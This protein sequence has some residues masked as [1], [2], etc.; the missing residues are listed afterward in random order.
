MEKNSVS[1]RYTAMLFTFVFL[2]GFFIST[3]VCEGEPETQEVSGEQGE[4]QE[5]EEVGEESEQ[6]TTT[7][8]IAAPSPGP[9]AP[10]RS[11]QPS[12][13]Q[14]P[15]QPAGSE[16]TAKSKGKGVKGI[17]KKFAGAVTKASKRYTAMLFTFVFL[18]GFFIS[19]AV[20]EEEPEQQDGPEEHVEEQEPEEVG[21]E[22]EQVTTTTTTA[23]PSP[24]P[25]PSAR[26]QPSGA[27]N[28]QPPTG[29]QKTTKSKGKGV[30]GFAKKFAGAVAKGVWKRSTAMLF[31]YVFL[32]GLLISTAVCQD[33]SEQQVASGE[34]G[35]EEEP[36]EEVAEENVQETTTTTATPSGG[37]KRPAQLPHRGGAQSPQPSAAPTKATKSKGA[38]V[39]GFAK[40]FAGAV[41][42]GIWK[43]STAM[44]FTYVF[45]LGFLISTAV[46]QDESEQQVASGENGEEEELVEEVAEENVQETTTTT[47]AP[48]AGSKRPPG[49]PQ[50]GGRTNPSAGSEKT[51]KSKGKGVKGLA[52][53]FAGAVT[54]GGKKALKATKGAANTMKKKI[55]KKK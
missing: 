33:E 55:V 49:S 47:A 48:K 5:P 9:K 41:T 3:A 29:G 30:K 26:P 50:P 40:K 16:K 46:C 43:R 22:S 25:K 39:K 4:E 27:Q 19:T 35:E 32:L 20:C 1:K 13:V 45:L 38:G 6:V 21:E 7:T 18:L 10:A 53:K 51:A 37:S 34:N 8:T 2:L 36:V 44:L 54:K 52:K 14:N 42:K 28:P 15:Q 24:R 31:T 12:G 23:A 11:P 17:A